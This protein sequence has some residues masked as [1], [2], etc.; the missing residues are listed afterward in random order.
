MFAKPLEIT[1]FETTYEIVVFNSPVGI[2]M[3]VAIVLVL[4]MATL[5]LTVSRLYQRFFIPVLWF[6]FAMAAAGSAYCWG[7]SAGIIEGFETS[8]D[9]TVALAIHDMATEWRLKSLWFSLGF[10]PFCV[11]HIA[12]GYLAR[13]AWL[14]KSR[15]ETQTATAN[16]SGQPA[17]EEA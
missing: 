6:A 3:V 13:W 12:F 16:P 7:V 2:A 9:L 1:L 5:A 17:T 8:R 15:A 14:R 10:L 11:L 4:L